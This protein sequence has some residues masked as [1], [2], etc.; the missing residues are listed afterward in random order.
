M[1]ASRRP[2]N[3][4]YITGDDGPVWAALERLAGLEDSMRRG[5]RTIARS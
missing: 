2:E 3:R 5:F 4:E 1:S